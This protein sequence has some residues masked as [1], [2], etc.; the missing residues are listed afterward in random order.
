[1]STT[2]KWFFGLIPVVLLALMIVGLF[3]GIDRFIPRSNIPLEEISFDR[4]WTADGK[5][6]AKVTNTGADPVTIAQ[7]TIN[8]A[9]W[10]AQITK[11]ELN[12]FD[13]SDI[14]IPFHW[15]EGEPYTVTIIT[16]TGTKF[17]AEI[18]A[19]TIVPQATPATFGLYALIGLFVGVIPVL[20][21]MLWKPFIAK[22]GGKGYTFFLAITI[23]LL[24]FLGVDSLSE[25]IELSG[26]I[27][28]AFQGIGLILLGSLGTFLLL[29][30]ISY[31][32]TT[33]RGNLSGY[34]GKLIV[35][36]L[37]AL[38][39]G[40]HNLGEGLAI[41]AAFMLGGVAMGAFL[42]MGFTLHN[43][44]EGLAIIA[45]VAREKT[46]DSNLFAHLLTLGAIGG[47]QQFWEHGLVDSSILQFGPWFS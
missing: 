11:S 14:S 20:L 19:A 38:G 37:V 4:V 13:K 1:M 15:V 26:E 46:K 7:V 8:D 21:G 24:I 9:I 29:Q 12:R 40:I 5:I 18:A 23:G 22:L 17:S 32:T 35:S 16:S 3:S 43:I 30:A 34:Q 31:Y 44:T 45:P 2:K 27:P 39:I 41:G 36:Y 25:A 6:L 10:T 28:G 42:I 33:R 47:L